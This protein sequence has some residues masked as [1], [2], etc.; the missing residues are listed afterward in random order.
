MP[1]TREDDPHYVD[2]ELPETV[3][4]RLLIVRD[5]WHAAEQR[6]EKVYVGRNMHGQ[7]FDT[8]RRY[9]SEFRWDE[10][11]RAEKEMALATKFLVDER[12]T[13]W[14]II[15]VKVTV[16]RKIKQGQPKPED[17]APLPPPAMDL[18]EWADVLG[19]KN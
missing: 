2:G 9:A 18:Q 4:N 14:R 19:T 12:A 1:D 10:Q 7:L 3:F 17:F 8:D 15:H 11:H 6:W 13:P 5:V 16:R